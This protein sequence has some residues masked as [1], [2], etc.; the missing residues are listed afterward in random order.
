M[1]GFVWLDIAAAVVIALII[2]H[3][4][5]KFTWDSVKELIDTGLSAED[6]AIL[7]TIAMDTDGVRDVL[8]LRSRRMGDDILLVVH[9]VVRSEISV[10]EGHQ[11]FMKV[12]AAMQ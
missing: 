12:V 1:L 4:G 11:I 9:V 7:R 10:S 3:I 6:T 8:E 2:I 5:W